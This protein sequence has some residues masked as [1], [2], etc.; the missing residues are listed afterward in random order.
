MQLFFCP[1]LI[2]LTGYCRNSFLSILAEIHRAGYL[3]NDLALRNLLLS[4]TGEPVIVD[5]G[6]S[7]K[8]MEAE[9]RELEL[10]L[11]QL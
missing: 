8:S 4:S 5:F 1:R 11:N 9:S 6:M 7:R 3:H 2:Q 10:L